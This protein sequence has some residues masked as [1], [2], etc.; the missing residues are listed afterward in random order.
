MPRRPS[1]YKI[2]G[3]AAEF[4]RRAKQFHP[5]EEPMKIHLWGLFSW[6]SISGLIPTGEIIVNFGYTKANK[7]VWCK[8]SQA[9]YDKHILPLMDKPL[10]ELTRL[11]GWN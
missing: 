8:P 1:Q 5:K 9:F 10:E 7:T 3:I 11:A 6:G 2:E 4:A